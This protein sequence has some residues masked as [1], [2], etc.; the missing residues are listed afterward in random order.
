MIYSILF[1]NNLTPQEAVLMLLI[2]L[3]VFFISFSVHEFAHGLVAYKMGDVTPKAMGRLTLNPIK[4]IDMS[5]FLFFLFLGVGWAKP[6]PVNPL[7]FKKYRTGM[8]LVSIAGICANLLLGLLSAGIYAI[9]LAT[10]GVSSYAMEIIFM[11]LE[12]FMLVN[13]FLAL[14]NLLP[15]YPLDGFNFVASFMKTENKFIK[16]N[17]KYGYKILLSV[18]LVSLLIE[19]LFGF[20]VFGWYLSLLHNYV[21]APIALLGV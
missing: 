6:M 4:H 8:R 2:S 19:L 14:F 20:D 15:I 16:F 21:F 18:L 13:S 7:N 10:V 1:N 17:S 9:L 12:Y 3:L 5:G 11:V